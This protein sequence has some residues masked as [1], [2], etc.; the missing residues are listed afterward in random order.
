MKTAIVTLTVLSMVVV[1]P[2]VIAALSAPV[3]EVCIARPPQTASQQ[4]GF[5][6][7]DLMRRQAWVT[8]NWTLEA[9]A[10]FSP[11]YAA[12]N[13]IKNEPRVGFASSASVLR[14]PGCKQDGQ[15]TY[16]NRFDRMF[17][18]IADVTRA[19]WSHGPN[20]EIFEAAVH[21]YHRLEFDAGQIV[22]ILV[23]PNGDRFIGVNRPVGEAKARPA[24]PEGW[25][26]LDRELEGSRRVD[27]FGEV[28][29]LRL[30]NGASYQG[31]MG[32]DW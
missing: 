25:E 4:I 27:L 20:G 11:P 14:S 24:L 16:M 1:A 13:W 10:N 6:L 28:R 26:L 18:H 19:G 15:F 22:S 31:P 32:T 21:K 17:F 3:R 29:V 8:T 5:E 30:Q 7:I 12:L 23:T 2:G 9:Y